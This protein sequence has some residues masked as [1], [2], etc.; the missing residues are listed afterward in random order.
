MP[1]EEKWDVLSREVVLQHPFLK[2]T[3]E[4]VRLPSG[5]VIEDWPIIDTRS[6]AIVVAENEAGA[7]LVLEGYKHGLGQSSWHMVGGYLEPGEEPSETAR[8]EL[9]EE[10][11]CASSHWQALGSFVVDANRRAGIAHLFLARHTY[12]ADKHE[13]D[14]IEQVT[15]QWI[16]P[17]EVRKALYDGRIGVISS[18]MAVALALPLLRDERLK[19]KGESK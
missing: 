17:E 5:R 6:Y 11:G 9:L 1:E 12:P 8:R 19:T 13:S 10:A 2:V 7:I 3:M 18:A 15:L 14:D 4:I 16:S